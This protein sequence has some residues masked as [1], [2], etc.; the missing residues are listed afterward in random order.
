MSFNS[1][2]EDKTCGQQNPSLLSKIIASPSFS[3]QVSKPSEP[4]PL[5]GVSGGN[6]PVYVT[7]ID[8]TNISG[9]KEFLRSIGDQ[10]KLSMIHHCPKSW[11]LWECENGHKI[12]RPKMCGLRRFCP[13]CA[14]KYRKLK[15]KHAIEVFRSVENWRCTKSNEWL[16]L[17]HLVF[18]FPK[19][20][21][22][23]VIKNP[24]KAFRVIF[25]VL[26]YPFN[27]HE[28]ISGGVCALHLV[29]SKDPLRTWRPHIHVILPN[30][31]FEKTAVWYLK[32]TRPYFN[33]SN[34]KIRFKTEVERKYNYVYGEKKPDLYMRY[35]KFSDIKKVVHA[36]KYAFRLPI[37]DLTSHL[38][39][40]LSEES[41]KFV[42]EVINYKP[43]RIRWF[44]F[45]ADGVKKKYVG[46]VPKFSDV[47]KN[48]RDLCPICKSRLYL[49]ET[50][51]DKPPPDSKPLPYLVSDYG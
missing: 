10:A 11:D 31:I 30:A 42:L 39:G 27:K 4:I 40:G 28:S 35:F 14:D 26:R 21:W 41:K 51:L 3:K 32:R 38:H 16:Y 7:P 12:A 45:L 49:V 46:R 9:L 34:L 8:T 48:E 36:L 5:G 1:D 33:E 37:K 6:P 50:Y 24:D 43:K 47:C 18:T 29:E 17:T 13:K 25:D 22:H 20:L 2:H 23:E 15:T 44:G 19:E